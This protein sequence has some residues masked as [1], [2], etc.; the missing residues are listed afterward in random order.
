MAKKKKI[1][2]KK[3]KKVAKKQTPRSTKHEIVVRVQN[4]A[5]VP[6]IIPTGDDLK[7]LQDKSK[8]MI[9]ASWVS[10]KQVLK[11]VQHTPAQHLYTRPAKG[12]GKWTYVTAAYVTKVLNFVFGWNWDFEV[13]NQG[14]EG[15][16]VWVLGKLTVKDDKGHTITKTQY[17]RADIK[18]KVAYKNNQRVQSTEMLDYGNDLKAAASDALKKCASM[19]GI[20]SDIYGKSEFKEEAGVDVGEPMQT[21]NDTPQIEAPRTAVVKPG[22]VIG[23]D[24]K[25]T[26]ICAV[27]G[28]PVTE[29]VANYSRKVYG[30][31]LCAEHQ[32]EAKPLKR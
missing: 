15:G 19:I 21:V 22:M 25:P 29:A 23:P 20:A 12:G 18:F 1:V 27:G 26:Y 24:N 11:M 30:K 14:K 13:V 6:A 3:T 2:K 32:R 7:P 4:E 10:E 31:V 8:Y 17:G 16:Q 28:E 9:P 5:H